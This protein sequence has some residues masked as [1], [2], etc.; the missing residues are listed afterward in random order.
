M[1][2]NDMYLCIWSVTVCCCKCK[3]HGGDMFAPWT[4]TQLGRRSFR[5]AAPTVWNT[6]PLHLRSPSIIP[7]QFRAALKIYLF[8]QAY[9]SLWEQLVLRVNLLTYLTSVNYHSIVASI[10]LELL[11]YSGISA[12]KRNT[13]VWQN[14]QPVPFA[15]QNGRLLG[16]VVSCHPIDVPDNDSQLLYT[17]VTPLSASITYVVLHTSLFISYW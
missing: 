3:L 12:L 7:G 13:V 14:V 9:T 16:Y 17:Y 11:A 15:E 5:V 4:R 1:R 10:K 6:L 8:N 2:M